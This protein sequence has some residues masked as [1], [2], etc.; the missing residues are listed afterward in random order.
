[1]PLSGP[2]ASINIAASG[3][4]TVI[5]G[6]A[7]RVI[8]IF[9]LVLFAQAANTVILQD[10]ASTPI[11][12]SGFNLPA[13]GGFVYDGDLN[14]LILSSGNDFVINLSASTNVSGWA[15]YRVSAAS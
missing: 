8:E 3:N 12:G 2:L 6:V 10:G 1:M 9:K 15:Y 4:N 11:N 13:Q 14:P 7:G 5:T